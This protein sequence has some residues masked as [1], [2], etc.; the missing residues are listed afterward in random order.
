MKIQSLINAGPY[1]TKYQIYEVV[2]DVSLIRQ[3]SEGLTPLNG[4]TW[5]IGDNDE[6]YFFYPEEFEVVEG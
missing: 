4:E 3:K 6:G 2:T 5:I 1:A